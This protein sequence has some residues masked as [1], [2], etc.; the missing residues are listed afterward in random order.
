MTFRLS[1]RSK[2]RLVGVHPKL[3]RTTELAITYTTVDFGV[4]CGV[5]DITEQRKLVAAGKSQTM[6]SKHLPQED[7]YSHAVDLVVFLNGEICWEVNMYDEVADAMK[8]AAKEVG[9]G[10]TWGGAWSVPDITAWSDTMEEAMNS[11]IDLRRSQGRRAFIDCPH[12]QISR[13]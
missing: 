10:L 2:N 1:Q 11:Y 7:G 12:Y 4:T 5:R 8:R 6:N 3:V 13:L 9:I